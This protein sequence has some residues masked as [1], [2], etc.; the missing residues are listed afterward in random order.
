MFLRLGGSELDLNTQTIGNINM[1]RQTNIEVLR[2]FAMFLVVVSHYIYWG[3]KQSPIY[4]HYDLTT[5]EGLINYITLE[6]LYVLSCV[7]VNCYVMITGYFLIEKINYRW[8]GLVRTWIVTL[9]Y[10]LL[11]LGVAYLLKN[12]VTK[13]T[14]LKSLF[15]IRQ[16]GYW[17]VTAYVGLLLIAP[18][19]S[20]V[21]HSLNKKQYQLVLAVLFI[22]MF[23]Y[24]YG[25]VYAGF[26][27]IMFFGYLYLIAGYIKIY[28]VPQIIVDKKR[29]IFFVFW[30]ALVVFATIVNAIRGER[31][32]LTSSA[33]DGPILLLSIIVFVCFSTAQMSHKI[34]RYISKL[35]PYTFGVYLI[36]S[37]THIGGKLWDVLLPD[38]F[39]V[40]IIFYCLLSCIALFL[41]CTVID[42]LRLKLFKLLNVDTIIKQLC[43]RFPQL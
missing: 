13:E 20:R 18:L 40:P 43:Q 27:S 17:F 38:S 7:A 29:L 41:L 4:M 1:K 21:A 12:N 34:W 35:G 19:L 31:F 11:F 32:Q 3:L 14:L 25:R 36:H 39:P 10:S 24:L 33:Y 2:V 42:F 5:L 6:P 8:D 30:L 26:R 22:I 37:N 16:S 28:G 23:Q 15:P 9:F